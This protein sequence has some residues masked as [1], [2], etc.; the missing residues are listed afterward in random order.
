MSDDVTPDLTLV[1]HL[2]RQVLSETGTMRDDMAVIMAIPQRQDGTLSGLVN[3]V[4]AMHSQ[5][6]RLAS[7]VRELETRT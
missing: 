4:R 2:L 1:V 7:R 3:E 5:H 6:S